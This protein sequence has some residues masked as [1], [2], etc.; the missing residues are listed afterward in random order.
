MSASKFTKSSA[1]VK[2]AQFVI[3]EIVGISHTDYAGGVLPSATRYLVVW[4]PPGG[5][6]AEW[7]ERFFHTEAPKSQSAAEWKCELTTWEPRERLL[8]DGSGQLL[9]E[10][11][12]RFMIPSPDEL[13][14]EYLWSFRAPSVRR[15]PK[16]G[17]LQYLCAWG[18][19]DIH[20]KKDHA[21]LHAYSDQHYSP[22]HVRLP[23]GAHHPFFCQTC[24]ARDG[25]PSTT[26]TQ[27]AK[28]Q[29]HIKTH[30]PESAVVHA[31]A[32]R[33]AVQRLLPDAAKV[34]R[35][36]VQVAQFVASGQLKSNIQ[37]VFGLLDET[38]F[39]GALTAAT[40]VTWAPSMKHAAGECEFQSRSG[41]CLIELSAP[42]LQGLGAMDIIRV[43][44][45]EMIHGQS[46]WC[47]CATTLYVCG[48]CSRRRDEP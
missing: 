28:L 30:H 34:S 18:C 46:I 10:F 15:N 11:H 33:E 3:D 25:V 20:D 4:A 5:I 27:R 39:G 21:N 41:R 9:D 36:G 2:L 17:K 31:P 37:Q 8:A 35:M 40:S 47:A 6:G 43:L 48:S 16:S 23:F 1:S 13:P 29:A 14:A 44:L 26:Y 22:F 24:C 42:V 19:G 32:P 12:Q 7:I 38:L 45:H